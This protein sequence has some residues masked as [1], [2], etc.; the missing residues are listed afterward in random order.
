M[1]RLGNAAAVAL[2]AV[3][4]GVFNGVARDSGPT[5]RTYAGGP[6]APVTSPDV[7]VTVD[8]VTLAGTV[9]SS[10]GYTSLTTEA[11]FVVVEWS[12]AASGRAWPFGE[13]ILV[14]E[15]GLRVH[16][17]AGFHDSNVTMTEP[18][19]T[20]HG[21]SVFQ[22]PSDDV[23]GAD[24][25]LEFSQGAVTVSEFG[26]RVRDVVG[27]APHVDELVLAPARLEVTP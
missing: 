20:R 14:T 3:L 9:V 19:F 13:A 21:T 12:L 17:R 27:Q 6:D 2:C 1:S 25:V 8:E 23:E 10:D 11:T 7:T 16:E 26:L 15:D 4:I 22:V 18:G 24:L 5:Q